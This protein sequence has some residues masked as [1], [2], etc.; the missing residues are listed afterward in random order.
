MG[1][2]RQL[3][4]GVTIAGE[5]AEVVADLAGV[6]KTYRRGPERIRALADASIRVP[7]GR[8]VCI[9]G[10]S[11]SGKST[12]LGVMAGIDVP[13]SGRVRVVDAQME[14]LSSSARAKIRLRLIGVVFQ[15]DNLIDE[16]SA[17]E[18]VALPLMA[19]GVPYRQA[20]AS[21]DA[22]LERLAV[23]DLAQRRPPEMSGG[24]RQRVGIAR[25]L[26]GE[27]RLL[28]ADEPTGALDSANS[29]LLF[30]SIAELC[31]AHATA[32][33]ATHDPLAR[34]FADEVWQMSDGTLVPE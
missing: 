5:R 3:L 31:R 20:V 29:A 9:Y 11:G 22:E 7:A 15:D 8:F 19:R 23:G 10:A 21:A 33:V 24:Q 18:N 28:L 32:V 17:R 12:L 13:D 30:E 34:R 25:A 1:D 27:K 16:L 2:E 4:T 14:Q 26:A 6:H